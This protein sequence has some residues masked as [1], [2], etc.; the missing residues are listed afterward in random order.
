MSYG[1]ISDDA[2][3]DEYLIHPRYAFIGLIGKATY[4]H[5]VSTRKLLHKNTHTVYLQDVRI[6]RLKFL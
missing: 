3:E 5:A 4:K 6:L 2:R 1:G